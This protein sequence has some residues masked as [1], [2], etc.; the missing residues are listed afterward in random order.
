MD[1][2]CIGSGERLHSEIPWLLLVNLR[3]SC[4]EVGELAT[5]RLNSL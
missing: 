1:G 2:Y 3:T 4:N 5:A